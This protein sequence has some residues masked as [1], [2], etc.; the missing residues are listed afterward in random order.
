MEVE[1]D[2]STLKSYIQQYTGN[3]RFTR[4][5]TIAEKQKSLRI[6]AIRLCLEMAKAEN[7]I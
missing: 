2:P 1:L 7:K 3:S 5:L 4:L 6:Y